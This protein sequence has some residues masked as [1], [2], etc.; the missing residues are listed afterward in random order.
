MDARSGLDWA[1]RKESL[2]AEKRASSPMVEQRDSLM[3][4]KMDDFQLWSR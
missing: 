3:E 4:N 1:M 2:M